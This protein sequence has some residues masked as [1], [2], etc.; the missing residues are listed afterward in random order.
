[1]NSGSLGLFRWDMFRFVDGSYDL[2]LALAASYDVFWVFVS[3]LLA[4]LASYTAWTM[5]DNLRFQS[6]HRRL[7]HLGGAISMGCGIWC[8]HFVGML[9]FKLPVAMAYDPWVTLAS[10]VPA[11]LASGIAI[12]QFLQ[13]SLNLSKLTFSALLMGAGIGAMHYIG[14][15]A[16]RGDATMAYDPGLFL[17]SIIVAIVL[18][19]IALSVKFLYQRMAHSVRRNWYKSSSI[20]LMGLSI[21]GMHYTAM[22]AVYFFPKEHIEFGAEVL[23][24]ASLSILVISFTVLLLVLS[25]IATIYDRKLR[26]L[27]LNLDASR[28]RMLN[29]IESISEGFIMFDRDDRLIMANSVYLSMY[30]EIKE[31]MYPGIHYRE[32]LHEKG[33]LKKNAKRYIESRLDWHKFSQ[34]AFEESISD[35]RKFLGREC[36]SVSGDLIGVWSDISEIKKVQ[37]KLQAQ[38]A[39]LIQ[40]L[41]ILPVAIYIQ[42]VADD[43]VLFLNS[44]AH[45]LN[46]KLKFHDGDEMAKKIDGCDA[47]LQAKQQA[48]TRGALFEHEVTIKVNEVKLSVLLSAT[49]IEFEN[50]P[51]VLFSL[52]DISE[53]KENEEQLRVLASIDSLTQLSNRRHFLELAES[54]WSR[55]KRNKLAFCLFMLDIDHFKA[56]NDTY[57]HSVGDKVLRKVALCIKEQLRDSDLV[58]R[59]GGE[60]FA[61]AL[62]DKSIDDAQPVAERIRQAVSQLEFKDND[63]GLFSVT[64]SLGLTA[65]NGREVDLS[66]LLMEA[67]I[68]LYESKTSGRDK[69]SLFKVCG[70]SDKSSSPSQS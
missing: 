33:A 56:V 57:G 26:Y 3:Y 39:Q 4:C 5:A 64:I 24:P 19:F 11:I 25:L 50:T 22:A 61:L 54:H 58:G 53:R 52:I 68:A 67:D 51:C 70:Q 29:A 31:K 16:M 12:H 1:M 37:G 38:A 10:M 9:A 14:M 48:L 69:I 46:Q 60:E 40:V 23:P 59:L 62:P 30:P 32:L 34:G 7:W 49:K 21:S 44:E 35:G 6:S 41:D 13:E 27:S 47:Y 45:N 17:L 36:R 18:A 43:K 55:C 66:Q 63:K 20:L 65:L 8:M 2:T 42:T 15:A 28:N